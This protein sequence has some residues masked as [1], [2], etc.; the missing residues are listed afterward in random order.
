MS[1][2]VC[3][4]PHHTDSLSYGYCQ[5]RRVSWPVA[6]WIALAHHHFALPHQL[7][8]HHATGAASPSHK[9]DSVRIAAVK[10]AEQGVLL[11]TQTS[12][13]AQLPS[14]KVLRAADL[15]RVT[16][17]LCMAMAALVKLPG[18]SALSSAL[19]IVAVRAV[20]SVG[21]ARSSTLGRLMPPLL[22][23]ANSETYAVSEWGY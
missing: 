10:L 17:T 4:L 16:D 14:S 21:Q 11:L 13:H 18:F 7:H 9:H 15:S 3:F 5:C 1:S 19:A 12:L 8:M 20:G 23:L 6:N 2:V 22:A